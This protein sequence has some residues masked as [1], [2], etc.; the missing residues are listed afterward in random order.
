[1]RCEQITTMAERVCVTMMKQSLTE[2]RRSVFLTCAFAYIAHRLVL[3]SYAHV[4]HLFFI[5]IV[6]IIII[7]II[8]MIK[9][10][11]TAQVREGHKC[12]MSAE[13][14]VWLRN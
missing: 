14:A 12:T 1:M 9:D 6:I 4:L 3:S 7:I 5:I 10:I 2:F 11:Y 13:M 8:I